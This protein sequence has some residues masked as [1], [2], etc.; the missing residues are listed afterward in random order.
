[1]SRL[2]MLR[3]V[4]VWVIVGEDCEVYAMGTSAGGAWRDFFGFV[5]ADQSLDEMVQVL[6]QGDYRCIPCRLVPDS[7]ED[8]R[9]IAAMA[10]G[11]DREITNQESG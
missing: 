8:G 7:S 4:R 11:D 9:A 3:G 10:V 1:M 5:D 2:T 6:G